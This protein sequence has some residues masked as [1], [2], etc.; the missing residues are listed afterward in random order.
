MNVLQFYLKS[1]QIKIGIDTIRIK[2][3]LFIE[4][5][6]NKPWNWGIIY[7]NP[8]ITMEIIEKYPNKPWNW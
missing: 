7:N 4:N 5:H 6:F 1:I 3:L 2:I 8:N